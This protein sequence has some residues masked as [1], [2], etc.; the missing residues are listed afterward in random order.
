MSQSSLQRGACITEKT[1][2]LQSGTDIRNWGKSFHKVQ[3]VT[4]YK[5]GQ[6]LLKSVVG[7]IKYGNLV[8]KWDNYYRKG[9]YIFLTLRQIGNYN[10]WQGKCTLRTEFCMI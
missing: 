6:S 3:Q 4:H 2:L 7:I 10:Y 5:V 1:A 9:Q 8:A